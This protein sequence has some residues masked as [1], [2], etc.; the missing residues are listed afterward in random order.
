MVGRVSPLERARMVKMSITPAAADGKGCG[1]NNAGL[2]HR[3]RLGIDPG[4]RGSEE[5][6]SFCTFLFTFPAVFL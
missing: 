2:L 4:H 1:E 3:A 5:I 6:A